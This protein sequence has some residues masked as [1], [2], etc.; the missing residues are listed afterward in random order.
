[1]ETYDPTIEDSYRK[2]VIVDKQTCVLEVLDTAGQEEYTALTAAW[3][4]DS[5][6]FILMYSITSRKSFTRVRRFHQQIQNVKAHLN[7]TTGQTQTSWP[8]VLIGNKSDIHKDRDVTSTEGIALAKELG[9]QFFECSSKSME[10][11]TQIFI[12]VVRE[13]RLHSKTR[14][15]PPENEVVEAMSAPAPSL[16]RRWMSPILRKPQPAHDR[17]NTSDLKA[18]NTCLVN[19]SR[20]NDFAGV[21]KFL[22][23]GADPNGQ[24]GTDGA[25][26]HVA[27]GLGHIKIVRLLL[28]SGAAANAKGPREVTP[29]QIAAAEGHI[30]TLEALLEEGAKVND[31]SGLHGTALAAATSRARVECVRI[32]LRY[33]ADPNI[34]GGPY[35]NALQA[36]A[37]VGSGPI[38]ELLLNDGA[39][40]EARGEGECTALQVACFAGHLTVVKLLLSRG[41]YVDAPGGKYGTALKAANGHGQAEIVKL[42]LA[43]GASDSGLV[44]A[45]T[46]RGNN[47][48]VSTQELAQPQTELPLR[49]QVATEMSA[50]TFHIPAPQAP[51][52]PRMVTPQTLELST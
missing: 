35:G 36:A 27:A 21:K 10:Q 4:R 52:P 3:I 9:C 15:A 22:V 43:N 23:K 50:P 48:D 39:R 37:Y 12:E 47:V 46:S 6:G 26:L 51:L 42:L 34:I 11:V 20:I 32:L 19:A 16:F 28:K 33:K 5:E 45:T 7:A 2:H 1:M 14:S 25:A 8:M 44:T 13:F 31:V 40:V 41:V 18:L 49:H 29:L 17:F 38:V 30:S 24:S